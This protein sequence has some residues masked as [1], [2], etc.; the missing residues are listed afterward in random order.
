M[1]RTTTIALVTALDYQLSRRNQELCRL[2]KTELTNAGYDVI[3][4]TPTTFFS[5]TS[6]RFPRLHRV[7]GTLEALILSATMLRGKLRALRSK[8]AANKCDFVVLLS[9]QSLGL[10]GGALGDFHLISYVNDLIGLRASLGQFGQATS[11]GKRFSQR[12]QLSGLQASTVFITPSR[13]TADDLNEVISS[14][15]ERTIVAPPSL[16][17]EFKPIAPNELLKRLN[18]LWR[19]QGV[20]PPDYFLMT[21]SESWHKNRSGAI[22]MLRELNKLR[23]HPSC[24][25]LAGAPPGQSE[26]MLAEKSHIC[27]YHFSSISDAEMETLYAGARALLLPSF[28]EGFPW[29]A[30]EAQACGTPLAVADNSAMSE[31]FAESAAVVLPNPSQTEVSAWAAE[32]AAKLAVIFDLETQQLTEIAEAGF[33]NAEEFTPAK[34]R[35]QLISAVA[36][37]SKI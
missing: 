32:S 6:S 5:A 18:A 10:L 8:A 30:A 37:S 15:R 31:Y 17:A 26:K 12:A 36:L 9:D 16:R 7:V 13:T 35:E 23:N 3:E 21:G 2:I 11:F 24:L 1:N 19:T 27:L 34:F 4:I 25:V 29:S 20:V 22:E 28:I 14:S 33:K